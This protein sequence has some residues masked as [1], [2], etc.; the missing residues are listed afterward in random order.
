VGS[1]SPL[2]DINH[3][4]TPSS[5]IVKYRQDGSSSRSLLP[6][7]QEQ[8]EFELKNGLSSKKKILPDN[9]PVSNDP[10]FA[11][12]KEEKNL[13]QG[14]WKGKSSSSRPQ[15][16]NLVLFVNIRANIGSFV[17]GTEAAGNIRANS[18]VQR[19]T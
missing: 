4:P 8:G 12:T 1:L 16:T 5:T 13:Y 15:N 9:R 3:Q 11:P 14:Y 19:L 18:V 2:D 17:H 7:L 6:L 10:I